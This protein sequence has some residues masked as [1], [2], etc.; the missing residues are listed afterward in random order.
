M[1]KLFYCYLFYYSEPGASGSR[2]IRY[3]FFLWTYRSLRDYF[4]SCFMSTITQYLF[5]RADTILALMSKIV[6]YYPVF[7]RMVCNY[8]Q[9]SSRFKRAYRLGQYMLDGC[10]FI[11]NRSP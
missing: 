9:S 2:I 1:P 10:Q 3:F 11:I 7:K 4:Y 6:L 8:S 5:W